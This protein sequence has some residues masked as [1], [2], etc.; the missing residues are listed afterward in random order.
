[1][2]LGIWEGHGSAQVVLLATCQKP[3]LIMLICCVLRAACCVLR[4]A[5]AAGSAANFEASELPSVMSY[6]HERGVKG[7]VALNILV[8]SAW[9]QLQQL[10][11]VEVTIAV[12]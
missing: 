12:L 10:A 11:L 2:L 1:V 7:Y 8:S 6:L 4:A 5:A 3:L 9:Q